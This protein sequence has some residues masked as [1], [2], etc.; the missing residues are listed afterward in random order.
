[1]QPLRCPPVFHEP[2]IL[3]V[4]KNKKRERCNCSL[5]KWCHQKTSFISKWLFIFALKNRNKRNLPLL[6]HLNSA[7]FCSVSQSQV[8]TLV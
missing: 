8:P 7:P 1:M 6:L 5:S 3:L 4:T 2:H